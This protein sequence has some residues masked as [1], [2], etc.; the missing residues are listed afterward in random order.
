MEGDGFIH[1]ADFVT[2]VHYDKDKFPNGVKKFS[3]KE[4]D[5]EVVSP[6]EGVIAPPAWTTAPE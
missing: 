1:V 4:K 6:D 5:T 2:V 3:I